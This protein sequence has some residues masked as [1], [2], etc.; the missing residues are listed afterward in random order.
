MRD[1]FAFTRKKIVLIIEDDLER[2]VCTFDSAEIRRFE[3]IDREGEEHSLLLRQ[4]SVWEGWD[5]MMIALVLDVVHDGNDTTKPLLTINVQSKVEQKITLPPLVPAHIRNALAD[6]IKAYADTCLSDQAL[7]PSYFCAL[8]DAEQIVR[9]G[10]EK[11][12]K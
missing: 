9:N 4:G 11:W 12:L 3:Q 2:V 5:S 8:D 1:D 6:D 7:S 10:L